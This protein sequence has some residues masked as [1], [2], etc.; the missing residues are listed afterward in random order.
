MSESRQRALRNMIIVMGAFA[1]SRVLGLVRQMAFGYY[2]GAGEEMDAYVAAARIPELL[3]LVVAGG[4]LGSAF[5]PVFTTRLTQGDTDGAWR[6]SSAIINLL[7]VIILPLSLLAIALAP[8][9]TRVLIAPQFSPE[10][11]AQTTLLLRIMLLSP[12]IFGVS[13][14]LMGVLNAHQHFLIPALAPSIYNVVLILG[15]VWGGRSGAGALGAAIAT[16]VGALAHLLSQMLGLRLFPARYNLTFGR[17]DGAV[18]QVLVLMLPRM[19]GVAAVQFNFVIT[20]SLASGLGTGAVSVLNYAWNLMT[21]PQGIIAQAIGTTAFP[22][23]SEQAARRDFAAL[24]AS[25]SEMLR[26]T[27]ALLFPSTVG[28]IVLGRPLIALLLERG[29]FDTASTDAVAGALAFFALGLIGNGLIEIVAR[30]FFALHDTWTPTLAA[31]AA[32]AVNLTLGLLLPDVFARLG[33]LPYAGLALA[34]SVAALAQLGVL[35]RPVS[36]R[37]GGIGGRQILRQAWRSLAASLGMGAV[38]AGW[39]H[40]APSQPL[41]AGG[42]WVLLGVGVYYGLGRAFGVTELQE[43]LQ[44]LRHR[45]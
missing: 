41:V 34:N 11:Q 4:A 35:L 28:L 13:G 7:I 32:V 31:I 44:L 5:I 39:L 24:R 38:L 9:L 45:K 40:L 16:V 37:L 6:L 26:M 30:V 17:G 43:T 36:A 27:S 3:F 18:R 29:A 20:N 21:L 42:V 8:W 10:L 33:L 23:F 12:A 19:L 14:I 22:T 25:V 15:A 2:F 1:L